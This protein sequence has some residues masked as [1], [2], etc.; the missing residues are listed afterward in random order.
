MVVGLFVGL[1]SLVTG[2]GLTLGLD[3]K[4]LV[5]L[6]VTFIISGYT[7]GTGRTTL[8]QGTVHLVLLMAYFV[9]TLAP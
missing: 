6:I 8:L 1:Y 4:S 7:L 2:M 5:F 3:A 9:L